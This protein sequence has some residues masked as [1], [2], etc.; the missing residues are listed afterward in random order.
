MRAL[1]VLLLLAA[2]SPK[3]EYCSKTQ[4]DLIFEYQRVTTAAGDVEVWC[5][6]TDARISFQRSELYRV[7]SVGAKSGECTLTYDV[8][9]PSFGTWTFTREGAVYHD[10]GEWSGTAAFFAAGD[11][12]D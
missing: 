12:D 10:S 2:C 7:G 5:S 4:Y 6:I 3:I 1:P 9:D 8:D 11:C